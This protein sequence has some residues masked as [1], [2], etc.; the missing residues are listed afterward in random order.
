MIF[1]FKGESDIHKGG[2][3]SIVFR[4]DKNIRLS[5]THAK[6]HSLVIYL[7][8]KS[9]IWNSFLRLAY[10]NFGCIKLHCWLKIKWVNVIHDHKMWGNIKWSFQ[11]GHY[12]FLEWTSFFFEWTSDE[13]LLSYLHFTEEVQ[14]FPGLP[15]ANSSPEKSLQCFSSDTQ[16]GN[17]PP[18]LHL[19][20]G[21]SGSLK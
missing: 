12:S 13:G 3:K 15:K 20:R 1:N 2:K 7:R 11:D 19:Q 18:N 4:T 14:N 16:Q 17:R 5:K 9:N 6:Y 8:K 10:V 21:T